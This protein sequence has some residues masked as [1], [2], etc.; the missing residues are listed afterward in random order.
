MLTA[1]GGSRQ[2]LMLGGG[3]RCGR[4]RCARHIDS[5]YMITA[6]SLVQIALATSLW[7]FRKMFWDLVLSPFF[8]QMT[9]TRRSVA[10]A[11]HFRNFVSLVLGARLRK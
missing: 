11:D 4:G 2:I 8:I 9:R 6:V 7:S 10:T 1:P 5:L 3:T